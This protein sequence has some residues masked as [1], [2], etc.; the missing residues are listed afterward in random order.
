MIAFFLKPHWEVLT[1]FLILSFQ[2]LYNTETKRYTDTKYLQN[3]PMVLTAKPLTL[4]PN[5][6]GHLLLSRDTLW[7][8]QLRGTTVI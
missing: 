3:K 8:L 7:V 4:V 6:W 5:P 2:I 1:F